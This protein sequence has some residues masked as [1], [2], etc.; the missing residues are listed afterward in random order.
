MKESPLRVT[1][2][3][4]SSFFLHEKTE[5]INNRKIIFLL[6]FIISAKIGLVVNEN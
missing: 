4:C 1:T 5:I 2:G 3:L 6:F